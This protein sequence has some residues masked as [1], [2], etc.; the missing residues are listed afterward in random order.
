MSLKLGYGAPLVRVFN[1]KGTEVFDRVTAFSYNHSEK[2]DD[3]SRIVIETLDIAMVDHPQLQPGKVLKVV[4]GYLNS[5]V[6]VHLVWIWDVTAQFNEQGLRLEIIAYCKAAY[7]KLNSSQEV[8]NN[9]T[10]LDA[11]AAVAKKNDL[12]LQYI[13][14]NS[15]DVI[16]NGPTNSVL[17]IGQ[18]DSDGGE[19]MGG[20]AFVSMARESTAI[21]LVARNLAEDRF[22]DKFTFGG[23]KQF[24]GIAYEFHNSLA[25]SSRLTPNLNPT[26]LT[27]KFKKHETIPQ[28]NASDAKHL[29]NML[30]LEPTDNMI[31]E[32]R[33]DQLIIKK[34]NLLQK[35]YKSYAY[36]AEPGYLLEFIPAVRNALKRKRAVS[37]TTGGWDE[38]GKNFFQGSVDASN[39]DTPIV[40]GDS[41][42]IPYQIPDEIDGLAKENFNQSSDNGKEVKKEINTEKLDNG[43]EWT[44]V[45]KYGVKARPEIIDFS[46]VNVKVL[47]PVDEV[48][49]EFPITFPKEYIPA[50]ET[51]KKDAAGKA[52]NKQAKEQA[53][54]NEC[55]AK[56]VGDPELVSGKIITIMNVGDKYSG[57]YYIISAE[58]SISSSGYTTNCTL[59]RN[60]IKKLAPD[61]SLVN[62]NYL[63]RS[64]NKE[65]ALPFDGTE[66]LNEIPIRKD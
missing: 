2:A 18:P 48:A 31:M 19:G 58:H 62:P 33:D 23:P 59:F 40:G 12:G 20:R 53:E 56:F 13:E 60:G 4:F 36:M 50:T 1:E 17:N 21:P 44:N 66:D 63:G 9:A 24:K 54:I 6:R 30:G 39:V 22:E 25:A 27:Y 14:P 51:N 26:T 37:A 42:E 3:S 64:I 11:A 65:I 52:I 10:V 32:G 43:K 16:Y 41:V 38:I 15:G 8:Y 61:E 47:V 46:S 55:S 49:R 7:L 5:I 57:N 29:E 45:T 35:P 34:R 28:G